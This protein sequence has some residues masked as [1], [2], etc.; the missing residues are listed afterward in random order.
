MR[1]ALFVLLAGGGGNKT[2][3]SPM[4]EAPAPSEC[5][6]TAE[7]VAIAVVS[8]REPPPA[9]TTKAASPT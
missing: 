3:Q 1:Y 4:L 6:V 5:A 9:P 7:H 2:P 8:W